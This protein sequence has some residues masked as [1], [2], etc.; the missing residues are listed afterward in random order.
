MVQTLNQAIKIY[1]A[2]VDQEY[3]GGYTERLTFAVNTTQDHVRE[4]PLVYLIHGWD[5]RSTFEAPMS[6]GSTKTHD[7]DP[8][9][10]RYNI[11]RHFQQT[12]A[13]V[14]ERLKIAIRNRADRHS[15]DND[16][17]NIEC[18]AHMCESIWTE[19]I[20]HTPASSHTCGMGCF[21]LLRW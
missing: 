18:G 3:W 14:N 13:T 1:A 21:E 10:W 8:I 15:T 7:S 6:V 17:H 4:A 5:P 19:S 16:P 2:D 20:L 11:Q 9:R 12:R